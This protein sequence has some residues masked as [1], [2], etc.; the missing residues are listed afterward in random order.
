M[1]TDRPVT[2]RVLFVCTGNICRSPFAERLAGRLVRDVPVDHPVS[3]W[4]FASAGIGALVG[5][6]MD[7]GMAAELT[8]RG[9]D[10]A[11]FTARQ[12][13]SAVA[14]GADLILTLE[15]VHREWILDEWPAL[16]RRTLVLGQA[17]RA[18]RDDA[19]P[20][21]V[22]RA[23]RGAALPSDGIPDPYRRGPAAAHEA[24]AAIDRALRAL[25]LGTA[26]EE[27]TPT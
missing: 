16:V 21:A 14:R 15:P 19:D 27:G 23:H 12:L 24:A 4:Q 3:G 20:L 6:P 26:P 13:T 22:L 11:E 9:G 8:A 5:Q 10:P 7:P 18:V 1:S 2:A 25:L 17:A